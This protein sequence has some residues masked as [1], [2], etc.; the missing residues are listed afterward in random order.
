VLNVGAKKEREKG[1][2][3]A[4]KRV[5]S[6]VDL[7]AGQEG[8]VVGISGGHGLLRRLEALGIRP[9]KK[10]AKISSMLLRGPVVVRVDGTQL[11]IGFGM[12]SRVMVEVDATG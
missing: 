3:M 8:V 6:L 1:K 5:M 7:Q 4:E 9:G 12:A 2:V 10:V 11:A